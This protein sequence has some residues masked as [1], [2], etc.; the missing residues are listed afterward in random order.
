MGVVCAR[1]EIGASLIFWF[2]NETFRELLNRLTQRQSTVPLET[3]EHVVLQPNRRKSGPKAARCLPGNKRETRLCE[4]WRLHDNTSTR[5]A[6]CAGPQLAKTAPPRCTAPRFITFV[7]NR[8]SRGYL[9]SSR[10]PA[11]P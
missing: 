5:T 9:L 7:G 1:K 4:T 8:V 10:A 6:R 11:K 2:H 3:I